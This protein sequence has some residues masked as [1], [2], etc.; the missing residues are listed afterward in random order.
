MKYDSRLQSIWK[1]SSTEETRYTLQSVL[2]DTEKKVAV[3][4]DGQA[5]AIVD[6]KELLIEPDESTFCVPVE[7]MK[8]AA[9]LYA[10]Q[11]RK[12]LRDR[13]DVFIRKLE[14]AIV[15]S[16]AN[17]HRSQSFDVQHGQF[18]KWD[19]AVPDLKGYTLGI[20]FD[21]TILRSL[22]ESMNGPMKRTAMVKLFVSSPDKP[23]VVSALTPERVSFGL[24]APCRG[25][26]GIPK[27][28]W[29]PEVPRK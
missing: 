26:G 7:A 11:K 29:I 3:V 20:A 24:L 21:V 5:I 12:K 18:P 27:P 13:K 6:I 22:L 8:A 10:Q 14:S 16:V 15:V 25:E 2:I 17:S 1:S 28:F 9:A 23:I 19:A 4:T